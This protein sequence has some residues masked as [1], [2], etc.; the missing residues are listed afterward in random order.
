MLL[1]AAPVLSGV[2]MGAP[3]VARELST[4]TFQFA[5]TQGTRRTTWMIAKLILLGTAVT[6]SAA[7]VS[8]MFSWWLAPF[9]ALGASL[10]SPDVFP[11]T[12]VAFPA[13]TLAAFA[14]GVLAGVLVR[15]SVPAMAAAIAAWTG[16][17][18]V[19][20]RLRWHYQ[21]AVILSNPR[22][23]AGAPPRAWVQEYWT[24]PGRAVGAARIHRL[25]D[26]PAGEPV[27]ALP[28]DRGRLAAG[29]RP[30]AG[31]GHRLAGPRNPGNRS[32]RRAAGATRV[33]W[34]VQPQLRT[35]PHQPTLSR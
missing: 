23:G 34:R 29:A 31:G 19:A 7:A 22:A 21:S 16:L 17:A 4:G 35:C 28:A 3:L 6:A 33:S 30:A 12:G 14:V 13:W 1:L 26:L 20:A 9:W 24:G 5:W 18:I 27:L 15:R 32:A 2:F 8:L 10:M 11:L 25:G